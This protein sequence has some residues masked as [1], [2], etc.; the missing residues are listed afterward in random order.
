MFLGVEFY[1][2][3]LKNDG[4]I[5]VIVNVLLLIGLRGIEYW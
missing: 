4:E 2:L 1:E 5:K 3:I